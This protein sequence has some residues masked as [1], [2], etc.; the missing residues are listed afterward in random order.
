MLCKGV[1]EGKN[2]G[3][4]RP[5]ALAISKVYIIR[6]VTGGRIPKNKFHGCA[7]MLELAHVQMCSTRVEARLKAY[8]AKTSWHNALAYYCGHAM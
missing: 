8:S 3:F 1:N 5:I 4:N 2:G 7:P 6:T